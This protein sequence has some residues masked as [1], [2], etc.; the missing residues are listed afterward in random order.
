MCFV[1]L[2]C[3]IWNWLK[4]MLTKTIYIIWKQMYLFIYYLNT[5]VFV[6]ELPHH[7]FGIGMEAVLIKVQWM[8]VGI[9]S[10]MVTLIARLMGTAWGPSGAGRTKVGPM[11]A[12]WTSLSGH[13]QPSGRALKLFS[14]TTGDVL[15]IPSFL[16]RGYMLHVE[17]VSCVI[18]NGG[19]H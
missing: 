6:Y 3:H 19:Q 5:N 16:I 15:K 4:I 14:T 2:G 13:F 9:F 1:E 12:P 8:G 18:T 17:H 7:A 11:L 10:K